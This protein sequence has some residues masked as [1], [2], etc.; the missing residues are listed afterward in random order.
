MVGAGTNPNYHSMTGG[1]TANHHSAVRMGG[2]FPSQ[3]GQGY[4]GMSSLQFGS[5][6]RGR[7]VGTYKPGQPGFSQGFLLITLN[8]LFL[9]Y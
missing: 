1:L 2:A 3:R 5:R 8:K 9:Q 6:G 4:P 7:P